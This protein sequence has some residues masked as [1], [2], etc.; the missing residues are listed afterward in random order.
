M[1]ENQLLIPLEEYL[2]AGIHIGT[3]FRTEDIKPF[4][5]KVRPDGLSVLNIEDIDRRIN[6]ACNFISQYSPEDILI[7][8]R[9]ESGWSIVDLM[10]KILGI[11]KI[12]GRYPP[13][14][15]TN[16]QLETFI[17]P[18]LVIAID[19]WPDKNAVND[20]NKSGIPVVAL[21]DTNNDA[22]QVDLL[23]PCNNKG[24]KSLGL[25]LWIITREYLKRRKIVKDDSE[26]KYTIDDFS[27]D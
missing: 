24:K 1:A 18:K 27:K 4:I 19:P 26:F 12:T 5:Y 15:L 21:C 3:K 9:R 10:S 11:K 2:K 14:I 16:I 20:A 8:C 17:E 23:I 7:A 22:K 6:V 25:V 13:G